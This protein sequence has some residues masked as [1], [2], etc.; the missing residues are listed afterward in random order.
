MHGDCLLAPVIDSYRPNINTTELGSFSMAIEKATVVSRTLYQNQ[1]GVKADLPQPKTIKRN[2]VSLRLNGISVL[3]FYFLFLSYSS[4]VVKTLL[5]PVIAVFSYWF[6]IN[7]SPNERA[8]VCNIFCV[9]NTGHVCFLMVL[10]FLVY[11]REYSIIQ[12]NDR[13][14]IVDV[15]E[16]FLL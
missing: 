9:K 11:S 13:V 16:E 10:T 1:T 2:T 7:V 8:E 6:V 12:V 14:L 5:A 15:E 4:R 3:L